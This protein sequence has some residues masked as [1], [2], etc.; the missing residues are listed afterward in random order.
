MS[1]W[2]ALAGRPFTD[3]L[4]EW[5]ADLF[6]LT[7]VILRRTEAYRFVLPPPHGAQWPPGR[8]P[9]WSAAVERRQAVERMARRSQESH[10]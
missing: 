6:A 8:F 1:T 3:E 4:L 10:P 2:R 9:N 7:N 5:P